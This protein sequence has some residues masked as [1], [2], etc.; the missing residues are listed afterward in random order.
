MITLHDV[1]RRV[2]SGY[3]VLVGELRA[4]NAREVGLVDTKTGLKSTAVL[5][6]YFVELMRDGFEIVKITRRVVDPACDPSKVPLGVEKGKCY[7]FEIQSVEWKPGFLLGRLGAVEPQEVDLSEPA[8]GAPQAR[9]T[10][11]P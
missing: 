4:V 2:C 11:A 1:L 5:I 6:T 9:Q 8:S 10:P 7:A 3:L